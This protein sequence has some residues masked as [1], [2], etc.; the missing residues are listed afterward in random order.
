MPKA[1]KISKVIPYYLLN[2]LPKRNKC[3][4]THRAYVM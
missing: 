1:F 3:G 2:I 4:V